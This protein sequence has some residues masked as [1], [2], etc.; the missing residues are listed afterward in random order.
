MHRSIFLPLFLILGACA[1]DASPHSDPAASALAGDAT[2]PGAPK[3]LSPL[4][5]TVHRSRPTFTWANS[6][7]ANGATLQ[8]CRS[9]ACTEVV[10]TLSGT[11][12][13]QPAADLGPGAYFVRGF[14]RRTAP[15]QSP[16]DG[17]APSATWEIIVG[18]RTGIDTRA[19]V[20]IPDFDGD[21]L[22]DIVM[23][24]DAI[25]APSAKVLVTTANTRNE[26]V[27]G[28][29][30]Y[31]HKVTE[32]AL[33]GD[34]NG[35]GYVD[36]GR[37]QNHYNT[38]YSTT[39]PTYRKAELLTAYGGPE[40]LTYY[41]Q[42]ITLPEPGIVDLV[43]G[44]G[45]V[46]G[47]GYA[48]LAA[49]QMNE[50]ALAAGSPYVAFIYFGGPGG[51]TSRFVRTQFDE[52]WLSN[53]TEV[54]SLGDLN[55]DGLTDVAIYARNPAPGTLKVH[56]AAPQGYAATPTASF[57]NVR[58]PY[59]V[60]DVDGDGYEDVVVTINAYRTDQPNDPW[61]PDHTHPRLLRGGPDG[62][63]ME[64]GVDFNF[65]ETPYSDPWCF[66]P[67]G[68]PFSRPGRC[69]VRG[70]FVGGGDF[71]GDGFTD[72]VMQGSTYAPAPAGERWPSRGRV[73]VYRGTADG[74]SANSVQVM[75]GPDADEVGGDARYG[76]DLAFAGDFDGD[77]FDDL[78]VGSYGTHPYRD[79]RDI[80]PR[81]RLYSGTRT[82]F[83]AVQREQLSGLQYFYSDS[84]GVLFGVQP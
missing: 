12:S 65:P 73:F 49:I 4:P 35:D 16:V 28:Y 32:A 66:R 7:N 37:A 26:S 43:V 19:S 21:G 40:R 30:D 84:F 81:V 13:A 67:T 63:R 9:R 15:G 22:G 25:S 17:T 77:G 1:V 23:R 34:L 61:A 78:L 68:V 79:W 20:T 18:H 57:T 41:P 59:A 51:L 48:D 56:L 47:D 80:P 76:I 52:P 71:D 46:D 75:S 45:D 58:D 82:G 29:N 3:L 69:A 24:S 27:I 44:A 6:A 62:L 5:G 36:L 38:D 10:A 39:P 72:L 70:K 2:E 14:G 83:G 55:G 42:R 8:I 50:P 74:P 60:G 54:H 31:D 33:A 64:R 53:A 11:T